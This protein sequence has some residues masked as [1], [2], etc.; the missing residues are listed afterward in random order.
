M[1]G[2]KG[3]VKKGQKSQKRVITPNNNR[4]SRAS[5]GGR[6][7]DGAKGERQGTGIVFGGPIYSSL[8][9]GRL[10]SKEEAKESWVGGGR[11][12][13][14]GGEIKKHISERKAL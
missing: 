3:L 13:S 1:G 9:G 2:G 5:G 6:R 7:K 4:L 12:K 11:R 14:K 10:V 8:G